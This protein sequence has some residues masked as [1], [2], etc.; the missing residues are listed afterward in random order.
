MVFAFAGSRPEYHSVHRPGE[1]IPGCATSSLARI[2]F[3]LVRCAFIDGDA[4]RIEIKFVKLS[5]TR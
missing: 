5:N 2:A 1:A 3:L 4:T